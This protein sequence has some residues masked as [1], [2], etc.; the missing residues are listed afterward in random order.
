MIMGN[1][2][3][4]IYDQKIYPDLQYFTLSKMDDYNSFKN[5]FQ[6]NKD[7]ENRYTLINLLVNNDEELSQNIINMKNLDNINKLTNLLLNIKLSTFPNGLVK[8]IL[9]TLFISFVLSTRRLN[10][11]CH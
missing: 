3:P 9:N 1:Y 7:N 4:S 2:D 6:S 10:Q 8:K 5:K 11:I